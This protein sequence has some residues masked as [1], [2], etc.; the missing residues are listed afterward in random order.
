M[1]IAMVGRAI[2]GVG[3]FCG[4]LAIALATTT[5]FRFADD[6][7]ALAFLIT[8]IALTSY[9]P[10]EL[11]NRRLDRLAALAGA[12]AFG[13]YLFI[14][15]AL[16]FD[17]FG[18]LRSGA[19]LGLCTVLVPIGAL[20]AWSKEGHVRPAPPP[21][22]DGSALLA[23]LGLVLALIGVWLPAESD[24]VSYWDLSFS[25]HALG[26]LMLLAIALNIGFI[27]GLFS[28]IPSAGSVGLLVAAASFGLFGFEFIGNAL[29]DFGALGSGG[30]LE[31]FAALFLLWGVMRSHAAAY[32]AT[33]SDAG[34]PAAA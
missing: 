14:P 23:V 1:S 27:G 15:A 30:W 11:D 10:A 21:A 31:G 6:G 32:R 28:S 13:F 7:T 16:G 4:L 18:Y 29:N 33:A 5:S 3:G 25:G 8:C 19:W 20:Y 24:G 26:L 17:H 2:A 34:V 22:R 12:A 9:V